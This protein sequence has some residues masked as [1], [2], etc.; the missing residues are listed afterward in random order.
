[1]NIQGTT[2]N[3]ILEGTL[4]D[5]IIDDTELIVPHPRI[6]DRAFILVPLN[7]IDSIRKHPKL[8]QTHSDLLARCSDTLSVRKVS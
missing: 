3:D 4:G 2:G 1:M 8:G 6:Q 7:E 5:D